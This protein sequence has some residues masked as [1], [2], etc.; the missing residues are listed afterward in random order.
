M[1]RLVLLRLLESYYRHRWLNL[2]PI[3]LMAVAGVVYLATA[4]PLFKARGTIFIQKDT[5]LSSLS[6]VRDTGFTWTTPAQE[7]V[8]E[9]NE[10]L[11]V[12]A[13]MRAVIQQTD[14]EADMSQ[15]PD[16][17]EE[18]LTVAKEAVWAE[19]LGD[20]LV[21]V[22][23]AHE[24][25]RI[26]YQLAQSAID[27]FI[28][29]KINVNREE[30]VAALNFFADLIDTYRAELDPSRQALTDYLT[31]HPQ[32]V[33]GERPAVEA[34][35]IERLQALVDQAEERLKNAESK[36][37]EARLALTQ[38]ESNARQS[39]FVLDAP[40]VPQSAEVSRISQAITFL[41]FV[42]TGVILTFVC[43]VGGVLI[44]R[45]F[46]FAIDVQHGINLPVLAMVPESPLGIL[47]PSDARVA[48]GA[49][50]ETLDAAGDVASFTHRNGHSSGSQYQGAKN[51]PN[52]QRRKGSLL[53][54]K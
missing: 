22:S 12:D 50:G 13:F 31:R 21:S 10:L 28:Q 39:Y 40:M 38:T 8:G 3:L 17:I 9:L 47:V 44:D 27:T 26:T 36:E 33:R 52:A 5:L 14:L 34:A 35:E 54:R 37:E 23:A 20:N 4:E 49:I 15:G 7:T 42:V 48:H 25:Q 24:D 19:T 30:S 32:P 2:V 1:I 46:R 43:V 45:T 53:W 18:T 11:N 16:K 51:R 41:G 29:W 6:S